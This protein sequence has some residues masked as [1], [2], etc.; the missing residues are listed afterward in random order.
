MPQARNDAWLRRIAVQL[1]AQLPE[2]RGDATRVVELLEELLG[3][4]LAGPAADCPQ[5]TRGQVL[6][7]SGPPSSPSCRAKPKGRPSDLPK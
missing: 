4:F 6:V 1:A 7:F 2:E 5:K 3:G